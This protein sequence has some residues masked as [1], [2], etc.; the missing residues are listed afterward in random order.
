MKPRVLPLFL[1]V[2][3][4]ALFV[5][6]PALAD[7]KGE[8]GDKHE[9]KVVRVD[10]DKL[11]MTDKDG[12]EHTH[13]LAAGGKVSIGDKAATLADLKAGMTICVYTKKGDLKTAT[14]VEAKKDKE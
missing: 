11:V 6:L 7:D 4:L 3:A 12:K 13:T 5:G 10:G 14:R 1:A 9:G 8:K 2:L